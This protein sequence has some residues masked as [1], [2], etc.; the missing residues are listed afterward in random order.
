MKTNTAQKET[1][2][3]SLATGS[4]TQ[5]WCNYCAPRLKL[6][7]HLGRGNIRK[8]NVPD[9]MLQIRPLKQK[10]QPTKQKNKQNKKPTKKHQT[11]PNKTKPDQN[12]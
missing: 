12:P 1:I 7:G 3:E 4:V 8:P 2:L 11:K 5:N 9:E 10:T 6:P